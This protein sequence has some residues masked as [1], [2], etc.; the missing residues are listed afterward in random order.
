[1]SSSFARAFALLTFSIALA[2]FAVDTFAHASSALN[3]RPEDLAFCYAKGTDAIGDASV[4]L[5]DAI[6]IYNQCFTEDAEFNV[7]FPQQP[8]TSQVDPDPTAAGFEPTAPSPV[9]GPVAW[10]EFVDG[11]FRGNGYDFTQHIVSNVEVRREDDV[12]VVIF[13][14]NASHI[15]SGEGVGGVSQCV[16]VANGVYTI[17]ARREPGQWRAFSLALTLTTFN[18]VF[19]NG[20]GC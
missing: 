20:D 5:D 3:R 7:W 12:A 8:F 19:E 6:V 16:A 9:G 1:M 4:A 15:I 10:A 11:V 14:L 2:G 17:K 18:P 13:Y